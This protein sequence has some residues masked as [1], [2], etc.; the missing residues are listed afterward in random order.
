MSRTLL[1]ENGM[2]AALPRAVVERDM[3]SGLLCV[4]PVRFPHEPLAVGITRRGDQML[5]SIA[6]VTIQCLREAAKAITKR[7]K[8]PVSKS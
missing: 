6:A 1:V 7:S 5:S 8:A 4:L 3:E 2:L